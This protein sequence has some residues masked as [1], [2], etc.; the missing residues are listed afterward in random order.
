MR[1]TIEIE[2]SQF[3]TNPTK[4]WIGTEYLV[5]DII[6]D[7]PEDLDLL[8]D[9]ELCELADNLDDR[10]HYVDYDG[11]IISHEI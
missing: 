9:D 11:N 6:I 2:T 7:Y 3:S 5:E 8:D 10:V 1:R 4:R